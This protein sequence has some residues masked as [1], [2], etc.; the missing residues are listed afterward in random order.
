MWT[1]KDLVDC[2]I[3][4]DLSKESTENQDLDLID[5]RNK[6]AT[7]VRDLSM[8]SVTSP[9]QLERFVATACARR[10]VRMC[11]CLTTIRDVS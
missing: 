9:E 7:I 10:T 4:R 3:V 5:V 8:E 6:N 2:V 1:D 11:S